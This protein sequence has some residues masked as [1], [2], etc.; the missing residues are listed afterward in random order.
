MI[1]TISR[2]DNGWILQVVKRDV[3][4]GQQEQATSVYTT[5]DEV[6]AAAK[7]VV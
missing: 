3:L 4:T 7:K 5:F 6:L 2:V 1:L